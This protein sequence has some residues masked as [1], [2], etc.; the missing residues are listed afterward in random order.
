MF[1]DICT[2]I[3]LRISSISTILWSGI[4]SS[5]SG[6]KLAYNNG[7]KPKC[8]NHPYMKLP[9]N[10]IRV[11]AYANVHVLNLQHCYKYTYSSFQDFI[12]YFFN[13]SHNV[14]FV[15]FIFLYLAFG[16][17]PCG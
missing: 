7:L 15:Q 17:N 1:L 6:I 3:H 8:S 2:Q 4:I 9:L 11:Q 5:R 10:K 12:Q 16:A 14:W 13:H